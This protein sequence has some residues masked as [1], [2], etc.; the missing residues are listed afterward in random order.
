MSGILSKIEAL[1]DNDDDGVEVVDAAVS[2]VFGGKDNLASPSRD[3]S[4]KP[5]SPSLNAT[6]DERGI[7]MPP[8]DARPRPQTRRPEPPKSRPGPRPNISQNRDTPAAPASQPAAAQPTPRPVAP[9]M[10]APVGPQKPATQAQKPD[11]AKKKDGPTAS[12]SAI[13]A[14][15]AAATMNA[16]AL[17][18]PRLRKRQEP[19]KKP[20]QAAPTPAQTR[21]AR[22]VAGKPAAKA[23]LPAP[24]PRSAPTPAPASKPT[25]DAEGG[26]RR[27]EMP[28]ASSL[29]R[30]QPPD[31]HRLPGAPFRPSLLPRPNLLCRRHLP[32]GPYRKPLRLPL[33]RLDQ[34]HRHLMPVARCVHHRHCRVRPVN[35]SRCPRQPDCRYRLCPVSLNGLLR[36]RQYR[37]HPRSAP[38]VVEMGV[39]GHARCRYRKAS[40]LRT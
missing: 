8:I 13:L 15:K 14:N 28:D 19:Q 36:R 32:P 7:P 3:D 24:T 18:P 12:E 38:E 40:L 16:P 1:D 29:M 5:A 10:R 22:P 23:V 2:R 34:W 30:P 4:K 11:E 6:P 20:Q 25:V 17:V 33:C 21:P 39:R 9:A 27:V 37:R 35:R 31:H 26:K